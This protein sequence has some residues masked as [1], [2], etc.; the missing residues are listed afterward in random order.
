M[1]Q[2]TPPINGR[3][4]GKARWMMVIFIGFCVLIWSIWQPSANETVVPPMPGIGITGPEHASVLLA[5]SSDQPP[6]WTDGSRFGAPESPDANGSAVS[7]GSAFSSPSLNEVFEAAL[8]AVHPVPPNERW[9][10]ENNGADHFAHNPNQAMVARFVAGAA[11][12]QSAVPDSDWRLEIR[13][14]GAQASIRT[15]GRRVEYIHSDG[16]LEWYEN[17]TDGFRH[18][19]VVP[20]RGK[21]KHDDM[22][23]VRIAASGLSVSEDPSSAGDLV[24]NDPSGRALAAYRGLKAWDSAGKELGAEMRPSAEGFEI[25]V[26]ARDAIYPVHIDPYFINLEQSLMPEM[27]G[28]GS[29]NDR[30]GHAMALDGD[31]A[32]VTSVSAPSSLGGGGRAYVFTRSAGVWSLHAELWAADGI[33]A[34]EFGNAVALEGDTLVVGA[35]KADISGPN[36]DDGAA[37]VFQ[38]SQGQWNQV[39]KLVPQTTVSEGFFGGSL[40]LQGDEL[41]VGSNNSGVHLFRRIGGVWQFHNK[42]ASSALS[43]G[44]GTSVAIS[45]ETMLIGAPREAAPLSQVGAVYVFGKSAGEWVQQQRIASPFTRSEDKF[46]MAVALDGDI[47]AVGAPWA[48]GATTTDCGGFAIYRRN[49]AGTWAM[50]YSYQPGASN[51][52][53]GGTLAV[54]GESVLVGGS[55]FNSG[56][57][58]YQP[59]NGSWQSRYY[60][61]YRPGAIEGTTVLLGAST[62]QGDGVASGATFGAAFIYEF[63]GTAWPLQQRLTMGN[64]MEGTR[65]GTTLAMQGDTALISAPGEPGAS[66]A[67]FGAVYVFVKSN[68]LWSQQA[69]LVAAAPA[70][71]RE[72]G[73]S[74]ALDGDTAAVACV[75]DSHFTAGGTETTN[76]GSV[77]IFVRNGTTW[78][79][80]K[81]LYASDFANNDS[82]GA[83]LALEG[84]HLLVGAPGDS[85]GTGSGQVQIGSVYWFSR[86]GTTW[87]Q[88]S[89]FRSGNTRDNQRFGC[90]IAIDNGSAVIGAYSLVSGLYYA[91]QAFVFT[92]NGSA[93][94]R[95][96]A[97]EPPTSA[98]YIL[99]GNRVA[100]SGNTVLIGAPGTDLPTVSDPFGSQGGVGRVHVFTRA[101]TIWSHQASLDPL[102]GHQGTAFGSRLEIQGDIAAIRAGNSVEVFS[103]SGSTWSRQSVRRSAIDPANGSFGGAL[104]M[105]GDLLAVGSSSMGKTLSA[106][107]RTYVGLGSV[108]FF[109]IASTPAVRV[110]DSTGASLTDGLGGLNFGVRTESSR[111]V[112]TV[113]LTNLSGYAISGLS[114][115]L[116]GVQSA[117]FEISGWTA[118]PLVAGSSRTFEVVY[119]PTATG[120]HQAQLGI[121]GGI[122]AD[123]SFDILLEGECV[124]PRGSFDRW[125]TGLADPSPGAAPHQDGVS[126]LLKYA[127]NLNPAGPDTRTLGL[128]LESAGL[129]SVTPDPE[130]PSSAL[131]FQYLRRKASGIGYR[132]L[133]SRNLAP[134]SFEPLAEPI[135]IDA[136][137]EDW[138]R[139]T[140]RVPLDPG[141]PCF[142]K[143]AV[144]LP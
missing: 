141:Q 123:G 119:R 60:F 22:L 46:G 126:N 78:S 20:S 108:E 91:G 111:T 93:W 28:T 144:D 64:S 18:G 39:A 14:P 138:E 9:S 89:K 105:D 37:Y 42:V 68:G 113:T 129:P 114:P 41:A 137:N 45:G 83:G 131:L 86:S 130:A 26:D 79:Q 40:A 32:V 85:D 11:R 65:L 19:F 1:N 38:R 55:A 71:L 63:D 122:A 66:G 120:V 54:S 104:A 134:G 132:P 118:D 52:Y 96:A 94:S 115:A 98:S 109:R 53:R 117:M 36:S 107:Q 73:T 57:S 34:G 125:A 25:A 17:E 4:P 127:F 142:F 58:I 69:R 56:S 70:A 33:S 10:G 12:I 77:T 82:F 88:S 72:F 3:L 29:S 102:D 50:D 43:Y 80:Q 136:L 30:F 99:F 74:L 92:F 44:F 133:C 103:R 2:F 75:Q 35:W 140:H 21:G 62:N 6:D 124:T 5:T 81:K 135:K 24:F 121:A 67:S 27:T 87:T 59:V 48:D 47:A 23:R 61:N 13:R 95:Q 100:I 116:T 16:V 97:I 84:N 128:G 90:A 139:V 15:E 76:V 101:G 7:T 106:I 49:E 112:K 143:V 31:T 8:H 110:T 51:L